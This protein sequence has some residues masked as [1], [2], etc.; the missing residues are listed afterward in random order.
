[1]VCSLQTLVHR[2]N[3]T[4]WALIVSHVKRQRKTECFRNTGTA[5]MRIAMQI[6]RYYFAAMC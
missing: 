2:A 5:L 1:M 4:V 3:C 6:A